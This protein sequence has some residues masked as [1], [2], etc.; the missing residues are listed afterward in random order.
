[1]M[2]LGEGKTVQVEGSSQFGRLTRN[3]CPFQCPVGAEALYLLYCFEVNNEFVYNPD[4]VNPFSEFPDMRKNEAWFDIKILTEL[5]GDNM[6]E[7][8]QRT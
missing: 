3:K 8:S 1:M 4:D 7:M 2:K 6:A 5:G